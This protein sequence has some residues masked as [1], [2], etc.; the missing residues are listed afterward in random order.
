MQGYLWKQHEGFQLYIEL[1]LSLSQLWVND[2]QYTKDQT[3][4][5]TWIYEVGN[6]TNYP[7]LNTTLLIKQ[8]PKWVQGK[9][10]HL[11]SVQFSS[12]TQSCPTL[13]DPMTLSTPGLPVPHQLP[14][15]TQ[16]HVHRVSDA[17]QPSHPLSSPSPPASNPSQYQS[18]FQWVN[19]SH[20]VAKVL[21]FQL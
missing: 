4:S 16:T 13:C 2:F 9:M 8:Q 10:D 20:E 14:E 5:Q 7:Y 6:F 21:E 12:V 3:F 18:L 19:S 17:I 1:V 15:F 11:S